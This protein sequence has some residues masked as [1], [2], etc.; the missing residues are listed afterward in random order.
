MSG[1]GMQEPG[2]SG[3]ELPRESVVSE[4]V[5]LPPG[6]VAVRVREASREVVHET[7]G[8]RFVRRMRQRPGALVL[9]GFL[10]VLVVVS[11]TWQW[12]APYDPYVQDLRNT[13]APPSAEHW[14]GTDEL[15]RDIFTR[16][17]SATGVTLLAG[18]TATAVALVVGLPAGLLAGFMRGK[19]DAV[20][21]RVNDAIMAIPNLILAIAVVASLG[22][23]I[24]KAMVAVGIVTAPRFFRVSR[25]MAL[26]LREEQYVESARSIGAGPGWIIFRHVLPNAYSALIVQLSI[27][28]GFS[29]LV[30]AGLSFLGLGV[31]PPDASWGSMLQKS[32][33]YAVFSPLMVVIPGLLILLTVLAFNTLGDAIRD[34]LGREVRKAS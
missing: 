25:A 30:E 26:T 31:Q 28:M 13:L 29:I 33:Q 20:L 16:T 5:V 12:Y 18:L 23:G 4:S 9:A 17:L 27:T 8:R 7:P 15:G 2:V 10:L 32:A 14:F 3:S 1:S 19:V 11:L 6:T 21:N 22:P 34:S 24:F